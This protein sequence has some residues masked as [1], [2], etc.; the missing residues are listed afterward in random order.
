MGCANR[1]P[2]GH[3]SDCTSRP[4][5]ANKK[6]FGKRKPMRMFL[7]T[8]LFGNSKSSRIEPA[9][10]SSTRPNSPPPFVSFI[11]NLCLLSSLLIFFIYT[12]DTVM[13][14]IIL[15]LCCVLFCRTPPRA[16]LQKGCMK[17]SA[18]VLVATVM[19]STVK[20]YLWLLMVRQTIMKVT[21]IL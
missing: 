21:L 7:R 13:H 2:I 6:S 4:Q 9:E 11:P 20:R 16:T 8:L 12:I 18:A 19:P 14:S 5:K 1:K 10:I 17:S 15:M 3:G